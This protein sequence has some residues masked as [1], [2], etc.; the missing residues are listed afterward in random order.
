MKWNIKSLIE[1]N[2]SIQ[3]SHYGNEAIANLLILKGADVNF[4]A[5]HN[6]TPLH[7]SCKWVSFKFSNKPYLRTQNQ[8]TFRS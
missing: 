6:I 2:C 8:R 3:A 5:K 4:P 1:L 7:V